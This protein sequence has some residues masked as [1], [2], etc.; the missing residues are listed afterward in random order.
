M[1]NGHQLHQA[2]AHRNAHDVRPRD[3]KRIQQAQ[4]VVRHVE[5]CIGLLI[6]RTGIGDL[7]RLADV[8][9]I[10][11]REHLGRSRRDALGMA[12]FQRPKDGVE[13]VAAHVSQRPRPEVPPTP[14]VEGVI[15]AAVLADPVHGGLDVLDRSK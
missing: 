15:D 14:E 9:M 10:T 13:M 11:L 5:E 7:A 8:A 2:S 3:A 4:S 12:Q 1:V 6:Q